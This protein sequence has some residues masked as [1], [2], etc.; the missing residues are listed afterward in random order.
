VGEP[1]FVPRT[2][3][4]AEDDGW[5]LAV[6]YLG[7]EHRSQLTVLDARG[8]EHVATLRLKHHIPFGFHGTFTRRVADPGAP[9]PHPDRLPIR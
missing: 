8:L 9:I 2:Q 6:V 1:I 4:A 7:A 3:D 5:L